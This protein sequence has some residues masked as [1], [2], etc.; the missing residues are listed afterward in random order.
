MKFV[1]QQKARASFCEL[2]CACRGTPTLLYTLAILAVAGAATL[3]YLVPDTSAGEV[4]LQLVGAGILI[5]ASGAAL[6]GGNL[7]S[8][9]QKAI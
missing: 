8:S 2:C 5:G 7:L 1:L 4:A 3:V 9:L 6:F